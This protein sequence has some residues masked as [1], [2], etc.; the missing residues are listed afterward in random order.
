MDRDVPKRRKRPFDD[1]RIDGF[2]M[3]GY[4]SVLERD[5]TVIMGVLVIGGFLRLI[6]NILSDVALATIDPRIRF[7]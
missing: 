7:K 6:G 3:L 4:R 2:G 5:F 1:H